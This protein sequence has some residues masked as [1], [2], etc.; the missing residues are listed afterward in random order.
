MA[1]TTLFGVASSKTWYGLGVS[2]QNLGRIVS[3]VEGVEICCLKLPE[4][5]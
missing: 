5:V 1:N 2:S 3:N 4:E